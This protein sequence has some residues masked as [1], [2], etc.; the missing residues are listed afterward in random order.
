MKGLTSGFS[1]GFVGDQSQVFSRNSSTVREFPIIAQDKVDS[2]VQL[3]RIAG[4]FDSPPFDNFKCSPLA[5]REK[6][7]PGKYRLLHNLSFPYNEHSVNLNIP[8][9]KAKVSYSSIED[10]ISLILDSPGCFLSK[11]DIAEAYRLLPLHPSCYNLTGFSLEGKFYFD[12]CLPMGARSACQIFER[13]SNS[14]VFILN[15]HF[16]ITKVVKVLDDFL[17]IGSN[18]KECSYALNCFIAVCEYIGVPLAPGKTVGPTQ[19]L[20]FLGISLDTKLM[21]ASI[22]K[23]KIESYAASLSAARRSPSLT[24]RDLQSLIGKLN[25]VAYI[26]PAGRCFLRRL[27]DATRGPPIPCR[28][29]ALSAEMFKD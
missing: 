19:C 3:G 22:P 27:H 14:L 6:S 25:F 5:L 1:L 18:E 23:D 10:A 4:P 2:E 28:K 29:I 8:D 24:L 11:S 13:F 9:D 20:T 26:I 17:F 12:K 7:I 21:V 15:N 16:S